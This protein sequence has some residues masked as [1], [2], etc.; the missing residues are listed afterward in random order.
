MGADRRRRAPMG[1][2][3][4]QLAPTG[5]RQ[6]APDANWCRSVQ[7][8]VDWRRLVPTHADKRGPVGTDSRL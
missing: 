1:D 7:T 5:A 8:R 4:R 2:D 6:P 3:W